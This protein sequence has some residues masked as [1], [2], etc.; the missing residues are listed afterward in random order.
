MVRAD[1]HVSGSRFGG[2]TGLS[3]YAQAT[4]GLKPDA[5]ECVPGCALRFGGAIE[6]DGGNIR[7][8]Y[9]ACRATPLRIKTISPIL[10]EL[11][12]RGDARPIRGAGESPFNLC[13]LTIN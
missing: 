1:G 5:S 4:Q 9:R 2:A 10:R 12:C 7:N 3:H 13:L 11:T 8:Q 6:R